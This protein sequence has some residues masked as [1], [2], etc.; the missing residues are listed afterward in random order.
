MGDEAAVKIKVQQ[1]LTEA[2]QSVSIDRSGQYSLRHESARLFV[3]VTSKGADEPVIVKLTVPLLFGVN[4]GPELH[5]HIAFHADDYF[6]GHLSLE[7]RS[8]GSTDIFFSHRLLGDYLDEAELE[9]AV[10]WMLGGAN[11]MDDELQARFGG[12]KFHED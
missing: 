9:I 4:N 7:P 2:F 3:E 5:E 8:D 12:T 10:A 11:E 6:F 1:Y